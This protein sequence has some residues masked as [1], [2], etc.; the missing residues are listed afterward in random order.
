MIDPV[1]TTIGAV[2][3]GD[4][5]QLPLVAI[6]GLVTS[7]GPCVAPRYLALASLLGGK[8]RRLVVP[9]FVAGMLL[10]Y[11]LLGFGAGIIGLVAGHAA[12]IDLI[13]AWVLGLAGIVTLLRRPA[14]AHEAH[15][16]DPMRGTRGAGSAFTLG[17]TSALVVSPCC[18]PILAAVASMSAFG[19][20]PMTRCVLLATFAVTHALP[21]F[22]AGGIGSLW[23][24]RARSWSASPAS[25]VV[26]GTLMLALAGYYGVLA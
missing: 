7:I 21:L 16:C 8:R 13:L 10:A 4:L 20:D 12:T 24:A 23:Q 3:R 18:T 14:C 22:F 1:A 9:A 25:A 2:Q 5:A 17:A 6:A 11:A 19:R 26:S 15:D